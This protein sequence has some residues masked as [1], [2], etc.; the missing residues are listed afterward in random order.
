M[1]LLSPWWLAGL[2]ALV[3]LLALHLRRRRRQV[4]V[5]SLMLWREQAG[6]AASRRRARLVP[7]LL[8]LLQVLVIVLLVAALTQPSSG[9]ETPAAG[10]APAIFV[11]DDSS[12]MATRDVAPDRLT[13][14]RRQ[15]DGRLAR[16][17]SDTPV[18]VVL[19]G[20]APRLLVSEVSPAAARDAVATVRPLTAASALRPALALAAGQLHRRGGT[21]TLLHERDTTPPPVLTEGVAFDA[22]AIGRAAPDDVA[23]ADASARCAPLATGSEA[24]SSCTVFAAVSNAGDGTVRERLVVERDGRETATRELTVAAGER[25]ELAFAARAGDRLTLR[26]TRPD[27]LA[28]D[29]RVTVTVPPAAVPTAVTLVSDR[30]ASAALARAL[31]ATPGVR[32]RLAAPDDYDGDA[33]SEADLTVLDRWLPDGG[34]PRPRALLLVAPPRLPGGSVGGTLAEPV[35]SG[36]AD[37]APLLAGVDL[38]GLAIAAGAAR[39]TTLPAPLRAIAWAPG[40]PLLATGAAPGGRPARTTVLTF[41]VAASTLPQLPA[42]P[43]LLAN[44][45]AAAR[46]GSSAHLAPRPRR[47]CRAR[48]CRRVRRRRSPHGPRRPGRRQPHHDPRQRRRR[49][50]AGAA[51]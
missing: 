2:L 33:A 51:A 6:V 16:L 8:L 45:V 5:D 13:A 7:S 49:A 38:D 18:T 12:A 4:E 15:L 25:V 19:A 44:V 27:A 11:L 17:P 29:D 36:V 48:R 10:A 39:Q 23:I 43:A 26:L 28:A 47:Q 40:G 30:P 37:D 21:I 22:I 3:P 20:A 32:L 35:L 1:T 50:A 14:A 34:L 42:F 31:A 46:P 24:D 41:D 9:G